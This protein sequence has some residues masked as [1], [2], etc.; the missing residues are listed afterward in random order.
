MTAW[1][2]IVVGAGTA[3]LPCA[4]EAA[5]H[6]ARVL[7]VEKADDVGGTLHISGGHVSAGGTRRQREK[8]IE[9]SAEAHYADVQRISHGTC[10]HDLVRTATDHAAETVDW[11]DAQ[12]FEF[13]PECPRLVYGHEPYEIPRT[14]YGVDQALS[15]LEVLRR[16]LEPHLASGAIDLWLESRATALRAADGRVEGVEIERSDRRMEARAPAVVLAAG[17]YAASPELFAEI[18]GRPLYGAGCETSTG[19]GLRMARDLG[20][21]LAGVGSFLP[22][23]GGLRSPEDPHRAIWGDRPLLV[24]T[25]R[26]PWEIYVDRSGRRFMAEDEPSMHIR[27][28]RLLEI[29]DLVFFTVFD[30]RAVDESA[31][32]V[33]GWSPEKLRQT[34]GNRP[35]ISVAGS[36]EELAGAA[37]I[38]PVGLTRSVAIY[39]AAVAAGHDPDFSRTVLPAAIE[40]PPFYAMQNHGISLITFAGLDVDAEL[41]VRRQDGSA[42]AG[43]YAAGEILGAAATCGRAF[44]GG[45]M[46]TP[47]IT[48]GRLL[49]RR[50][51][52]G[53]GG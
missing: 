27:E 38:D 5:D 45:M 35:G 8:Q 36:V 37:G 47:A 7:L 17:G 32:I 41:R 43:L 46:L 14:Y 50:L 30:D 20:A 42:I 15:I 33:V 26:D 53:G 49:G 25:E 22:T 10:R 44:C 1:D 21:G 52:P 12:G 11:L 16:L 9:D 28:E 24:P 29:D 31:N 18:E 40:T 6:G 19:D 3:G 34:A 23:F 39:N 2:L 51:A 13:A 48:F 4:I